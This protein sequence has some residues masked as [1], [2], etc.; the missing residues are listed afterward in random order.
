MPYS[1]ASD[2]SL[3][4][5]VRQASKKRRRRFV[6][7]FN[8]SLREEP[9]DEGRAHRI[10]RAAMDRRADARADLPASLGG[11]RVARRDGCV[12]RAWLEAL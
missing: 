3:P 2:P 12:G 11:K 7:A 4:K 8:A 9:D 1:S 5:D 6:A 10:A